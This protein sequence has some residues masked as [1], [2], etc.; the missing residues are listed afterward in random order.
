MTTPSIR[1]DD[2]APA[3]MARR[4]SGA[5]PRRGRF[6]PELTGFAFVLP[7]LVAYGLFLI[8]PAILGAR[9]SLFDWS[10]TGSGTGDFVGLDN[11]REVWN[12]PNFWES[13]QHT[14][15]FTVL[16][17][18]T[19]VILSFL[20]AVL[21]N[22]RIPAQW[23][24]RLSFFAPFLLPSAVIAFIWTWIYQPEFG[25]INGLLDGWGLS[26]VGW[27]TDQDVAMISV[28]I[29][30]VWWTI[31]FNFVLYLAGLQEIGPELYE[32]AELDGASGWRKV[33]DITIP[34]LQRTTILIVILQILASLQVFDQI[35]IMTSGG[36]NFSTRPVIQYAY[37]N[38]FTNFRIGYASAMSYAFFVLV[39]AISLTGFWLSRRMGR[40]V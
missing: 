10:L 38:G 23:L 19:L 32:A 26:T 3:R 37:E 27:L 14:A 2:I 8:W 17:V 18:P 15:L 33:I 11:Y 28:A 25:V 20:F 6:G 12:D 34:L 22:R 29:A 5:R 31:G 35:F 24:F 9:I 36:P 16:T 4:Q 40:N 39:I 21:A 7:F 30:T 13:L 1:S